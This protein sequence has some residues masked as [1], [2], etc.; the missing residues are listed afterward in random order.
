M[1]P[2][3]GQRWGG[4]IRRDTTIRV[5]LDGRPV[6]EKTYRPSG[7]RSDGPT[8]VY[9]EL[10]LQ[11]GSHRLEATLAEGIGSARSEAPP[12]AR[13]L[14]AEVEV[15]PG[16]VLLLELSSQQELALRGG[17]PPRPPGHR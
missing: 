3:G 12:P 9:E 6:L 17:G 11:P 15:S 10:D 5:T 14:V 4:R 2:E 7:L 16:Q 1:R 8:F 13:R